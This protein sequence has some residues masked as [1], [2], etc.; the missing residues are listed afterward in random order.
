MKGIRVN[1][2]RLFEWTKVAIDILLCF[3]E[4][5]ICGKKASNFAF[6]EKNRK[7]MLAWAAILK[8]DEKLKAKASESAEQG[9]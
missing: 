4:R 6:D 5:L 7:L 9:A 3:S 1:V 8:F 2:A